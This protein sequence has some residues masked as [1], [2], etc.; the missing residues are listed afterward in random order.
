MKESI[1]AI[2]ENYSEYLNPNFPLK[3]VSFLDFERELE[4]IRSFSFLNFTEVGRSIENRPITSIR[5]G[6]GQKKIFIW[7]Q[8][9]GNEA[10]A[11]RALFD[12]FNALNS[13]ENL[14]LRKQLAS[15]LQILC[16]PMLNPDG[17]ERYQRRNALD[18]DPN[19]D[20]V[21]RETPEIRLLFNTIEEYQPDW[22]FNM[23]DQRNL[24][25]VFGTS[26]PATISFLSPS[27]SIEGTPT[28]VQ[29]QAMQLIDCVASNLNAVKNIGIA[30]FSHEYYPTATGDNIQKIG[31][32]TILIESGGYLGDSDRFVAR[33]VVFEALFHSFYFIA[34]NNWSKG[35]LKN[36]L[37]IPKNDTKLFDLIVRNV[38]LDT[39]S[40][41]RADLGI[42][43]SESF[44]SSLNQ[45]IYKSVIKDIGDLTYY[46]GYDEL[47]AS[48]GCITRTISLNQKADFD[49]AFDKS[50]DN[51]STII[52]RN[53]CIQ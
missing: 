43:F 14:E 4:A 50:I 19:R 33:K 31:H 37:K 44:D 53:G 13:K 47:N 2:I 25:N 52:I 6:S 49:I 16:L 18:V 20:A 34:T 48:G 5:F 26:T 11:T 51:K 36:Y 39:S 45:I 21:K 10:T 29:E 42:E 7:T 1:N 28:D 22:C 40:E 38:Q 15:E 12:V 46:F 23:H 17:A 30:R 27:T 32:R 35:T 41:V 24:F 8:M 3:R 9:H